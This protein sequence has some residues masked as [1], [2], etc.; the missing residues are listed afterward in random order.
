MDKQISWIWLRWTNIKLGMLGISWCHMNNHQCCENKRKNKGKRI[1][2]KKTQI[3]LCTQ[4]KTIYW[5]V[6][7]E[8]DNF[9]QIVLFCK[10]LSCLLYTWKHLF[11]NCWFFV[12]TNTKLTSVQHC[13]VVNC[14]IFRWWFI[15]DGCCRDEIPVNWFFTK[16]DNELFE[17]DN[18]MYNSENFIG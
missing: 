18:D 14:V 7:K 4:N 8:Q 16:Q 13:M 2:T 11:A 1:K 6:Y 17:T 9:L 12:S 5:L 3:D 15:V 10:K